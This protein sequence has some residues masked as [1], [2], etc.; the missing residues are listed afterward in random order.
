MEILIVEDHS[1]TIAGYIS[2]LSELF[3]S[4]NFLK[5]LNCLEAYMEI[6]TSSK[7]D[8]AIID[9]QLPAFQEKNLYSGIDIALLIKK[10]H[11][12]CR[13]MIITAYEE[14]TT[15]YTIYTK[16]SP[17]ALLIKSDLVNFNFLHNL[18]YGQIYLS[19]KAQEAMKTLSQQHI[20]FDSINCEILVYLKVGY[21][22]NELE[23]MISLSRSAI[24]KRIKKMRE[25]F[26]ASDTGELIRK[27]SQ[28][29]II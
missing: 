8:W 19:K 5:A 24:E 6:T 11:P 14:V 1:M 18:P 10:K 15:I 13:I 25:Y 17:D 23:N 12:N 21:R 3:P 16:A 7:L 28:E 22:P 9:Y 26:D 29:K 2:I 20:L 27:A 4:A